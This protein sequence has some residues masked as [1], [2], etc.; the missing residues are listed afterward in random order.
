MRRCHEGLIMKTRNGTINLGKNKVKKMVKI[1]IH[2]SS[3]YI[4][5]LQVYSTTKEATNMQGRNKACNIAIFLLKNYSQKF[6]AYNKVHKHVNFFLHCFPYLY[7]TF[8]NYLR[9]T[10]AILSFPVFPYCMPIFSFSI[11]A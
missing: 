3:I 1:S 5:I 7:I 8:Q 10:K 11:I 2:M 6:S 4:C 9:S